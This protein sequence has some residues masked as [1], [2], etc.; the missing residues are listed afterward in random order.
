MFCSHCGKEVPDGAYVCTHCG[1]LVEKKKVE[2]S[3]P[4]N[5]MAILALIFSLF[6][7]LGLVF[8]PI[9]LVKA[10]NRNGVGA[11]M[12]SFAIVLSIIQLILFVTALVAAGV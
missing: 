6:G 11:R 12:A 8:G 1:F 3:K 9:A 2:P 10:K 4:S 7:V 5:P